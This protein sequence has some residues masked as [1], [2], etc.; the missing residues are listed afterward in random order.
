MKARRRLIGR[1]RRYGMPEQPA[2]PAWLGY[3]QF[4]PERRTQK[5]GPSMGKPKHARLGSGVVDYC[6]RHS[7]QGSTTREFR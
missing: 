1:G 7:E 4:T 6:H 2:A 5:P 3:L